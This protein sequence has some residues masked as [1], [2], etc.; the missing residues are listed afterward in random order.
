[1]GADVIG[2]SSQRS[3]QQAAFVEHAALPFAL[4]SDVDLRVGTALQLP[5]FRVAGTYRY[6]RQTLLLDEAGRI[7]H[8]QMPIT[9]PAESV[10]EML[11]ALRERTCQPWLS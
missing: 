8:T 7:R 11:H 4:L 6:K 3:D 1:M 5:A 9:D 10:T 2:I